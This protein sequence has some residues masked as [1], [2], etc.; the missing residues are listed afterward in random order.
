MVLDRWNKTAHRNRRV[1]YASLKQEES[2]VK[3][4]EDIIKIAHLVNK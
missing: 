3:L 1:H 4:N 2:Q